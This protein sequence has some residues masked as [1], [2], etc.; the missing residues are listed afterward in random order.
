MKIDAFCHVMPREYAERLEAVGD[1]PAAANIRNRIAGIPS[2]V[3]L[4]LRFAQM[5]EFG[6]DYRQ[7]VSLPAPP[8]ED[9]GAAAAA[10]ASSRGSA[11]RASR[12]SSPSTPTA[13]RASSR[14]C[15]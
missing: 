2:M 13:S 12:A 14:S 10:G 4:D 5:D 15:R 11:T 3:D 7:V 6:D 1:A 9:L 8:I